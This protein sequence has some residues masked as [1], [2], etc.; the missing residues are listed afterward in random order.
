MLEVGYHVILASYCFVNGYDRVL[1]IR[2][3]LQI[4]R[5]VYV[6]STLHVEK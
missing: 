2:H 5:L 1:K 6:I 3:F 4:D